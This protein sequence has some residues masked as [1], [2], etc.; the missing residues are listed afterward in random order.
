[1]T[2]D[3]TDLTD[4]MTTRESPDLRRRI[5]KQIKTVKNVINETRQKAKN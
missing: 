4:F 2:L 1:V 5:K 3:L